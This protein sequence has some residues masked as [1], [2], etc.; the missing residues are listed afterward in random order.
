MGIQIFIRHEIDMGPVTIYTVLFGWEIR[1]TKRARSLR[2]KLAH[3]SEGRE[4]KK[5][6]PKNGTSRAKNKKKYKNNS[7]GYG[8]VLYNVILECQHFTGSRIYI[9]N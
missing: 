9:I 2:K 1:W 5:P 8:M 3:N 6:L 7:C 4:T